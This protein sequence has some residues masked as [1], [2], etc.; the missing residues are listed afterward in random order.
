MGY[1]VDKDKQYYIDNGNKPIYS[2]TIYPKY[3]DCRSESINEDIKVL[4]DRPLEE[5]LK[6][7]EKI[8]GD[9]NDNN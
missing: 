3:I 8:T 5:M 6:E 1:I 2:K 4:K 7:M 9:R